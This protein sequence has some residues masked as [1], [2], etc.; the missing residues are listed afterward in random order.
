M[1]HLAEHEREIECDLLVAGSGA[2]ALTA[3][4]VASCHGLDV[5]V[6]EKEDV[7]GGTSAY[8]G[9]WLWVPDNRLA[10]EAGLQDSAEQAL[11]YLRHEVGA[12]FDQE[13]AEAYVSTAAEMMEFVEEH[14]PVKFTL[15]AALPDYHPNAPGAQKGGRVVYASAWDGRQM[16]KELER[17]RKTHRSMAIGGIQIGNEDIEAFVSSGRKLSSFFRVLKLLIGSGLDMVR[18]GQSTRLTNGR[19]LVGGLATAALAK[20]VKLW[21]GSPVRRLLCEHGDVVGAVVQRGGRDLVVRSRRGVVLATGG[22]PHDSRRR[23]QLVGAIMN[24][25]AT[26]AVAWGL[27]PRGNTGDGLRMAEKVGGKYDD[28]VIDP[29]AYVP[30]SKAIGV[31]GDFGVFPAFLQRGVPGQVC[32]TADGKRF[33]SEGVSYHDWG[34]A[35]IRKS[36]SAAETAAWFVCDERTLK[37]YGLI[38]VPPWPMSYGSFVRAGYLKKGESIRELAEAAGINP[39]G[40]E[41]AVNRFNA[42]MARGRDSDFGRGENPYELMNGDPDHRPN[43]CLGPL[44][45]GPYFAVKVTVACASTHAGLATNKN[46]Q[47]LNADGTAIRG[48]YAVGTDAT[49]VSGG[50]I[51]AGGISIGPAMTFGYIA[52]QHAAEEQRMPELEPEGAKRN[53]VQDKATQ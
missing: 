30:V 13:R 50:V 40:L 45:R 15:H 9:G 32:V 31:E 19:A 20:G 36:G 10:R 1:N 38:A 37:K 28:R 35:L 2:G 47:V 8:S 21:T 25:C 29:I 44:G 42:D 49:S 23:D 3:A 39:D 6:A 53:E 34:A 27:M 7:F 16:G 5:I 22:F 17:L 12:H 4:L 51:L 18:S 46:A 52:A 11:A 41:E 33:V 26:N 48:L 14:S 43:P 24:D